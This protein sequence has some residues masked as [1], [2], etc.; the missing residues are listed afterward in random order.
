MDPFEIK[1]VYNEITDSGNIKKT[2]VTPTG[3]YKIMYDDKIK[4]IKEKIYRLFGGGDEDDDGTVEVSSYPS[5]QKLVV[6]DPISNEK[7]ILDGTKLVRGKIVKLDDQNKVLTYFTTNG[8]IKDNTIYYESII[9]I[10]EKKNITT[11]KEYIIFEAEYPKITRDEF[12]VAL[13]SIRDELDINE[14]DILNRFYRKA[15][16]EAIEIENR[17]SIL[18]KGYQSLKMNYTNNLRISNNINNVFNYSI[19]SAFI[20]FKSQTAEKELMGEKVTRDFLDFDILFNQLK[21]TDFIPLISYSPESGK[22]YTKVYDKLRNNPETK[23]MIENWLIV[24]RDI[25]RNK[26]AQ[27]K[28]P[29]GLTFR[30]LVDQIKKRYILVNLFRDGKVFMRCSFKTEEYANEKDIIK[31]MNEFNKVIA[32]INRYKVAI[33]GS[34]KKLE[35]LEYK[36]INYRSI[37]VI[38][39]LKV[40]IDKNS[41]RK[42][43]SNSVF[44]EI[45]TVDAEKKKKEQ[46]CAELVSMGKIS[47]DDC[48]KMKVT[49]VKE[50]AEANGINLK[51]SGGNDQLVINYNRVSSETRTITKR[52]GD[53]ISEEAFQKLIVSFKTQNNNE[54]GLITLKNVKNIFQILQILNVS[55]SLINLTKTET[56]QS[57]KKQIKRLDVLKKYNVPVNTRNCQSFRQ[58]DVDNDGNILSEETLRKTGSYS[59]KSDTTNGVRLVCTGKGEKSKDMLFPGYTT[60]GIPCCFTYDQRNEPQWK[61]F[62]N[63]DENNTVTT[64]NL[65]IKRVNI[66]KTDKILLPGRL[67]LITN[68]I[69]EYF[70]QFGK[71]EYKDFLRLGV[72]QNR[73]SFLSAVFEVTKDELDVNSIQEFKESLIDYLNSNDNIFRILQ[74][75]N[76]MLSLSKS[77]FIDII[78]NG[79][80]GDSHKYLL[81]LVALYTEKNIF[82]F[83]EKSQNIICYSDFSDMSQ[84]LQKHKN[85]IFLIKKDAQ[86]EPIINV[87]LSGKITKTFKSSDNIVKHTKKIYKLSCEETPAQISPVTDALT[88]RE[89]INKTD[90]TLGIGI[91]TDFKIVSQ[92]VNSENKVIFAVIE[93]KNRDS[94]TNVIKQFL[95]PMK[96]TGA[97]PNYNIETNYSKYK[98]SAKSTIHFLNKLSRICDQCKFDINAQIL[99]KG[100][101][102]ALLLKNGFAVPVIESDRLRRINISKINFSVDLEKFIRSGLQI[103]D[104]RIKLMSQ[105]ALN[106]GLYQQVRFETSNILDNKLRKLLQ[107]IILNTQTSDSYKRARIN[108]IIDPFL[109]SVSLNSIVENTTKKSQG[110]CKGA[111]ETVCSANPY[112]IYYKS[113][114]KIRIPNDKFNY[115]KKRLIQELITDTID[116]LIIKGLVTLEVSDVDEFIKRP[117]ETVLVNIDQALA[118][119]KGT[120]VK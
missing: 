104:H 80:G 42:I 88:I 52:Y 111:S 21:V 7:V 17:L 48:I 18:A 53:I 44:N 101:I 22:V 55:V 106:K 70:R 86:Y 96:P 63:T 75:G 71:P 40:I 20:E 33:K 64:G 109:K 50:I 92:I 113:E 36:D 45:F 23:K 102:I 51:E 65:Q 94:L 87:P 105:I 79:A 72:T 98:Q 85:T 110:L 108:E 6:I 32:E 10:L 37:D 119:I 67:G 115:I 43:A 95:V 107:E 61:N 16:K 62:H 116:Q 49:K 89:F 11:P 74:N 58:P 99:E 15:K 97:I 38:L 54:F 90:K 112:C 31:C 24:E 66:I 59:I 117:N 2:I 57:N 12:E 56:T 29:Q 13:F 30:I 69:E 35:K 25:K 68:V 77:E 103:N 3:Q 41:I 14:N 60:K 8:R 114:C 118:W 81:E 84:L 26:P 91:G 19:I 100:K 76:L 5:F 4:D 78:M 9:D 46:L 1:I 120:R 27:F 39:K 28:N 82:I 73:E 47:K 93:Y 34:E 83:S